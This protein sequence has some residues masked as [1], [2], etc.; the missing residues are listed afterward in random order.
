[1]PE[2]IENGKAK[3]EEMMTDEQRAAEAELETSIENE[4][5]Q[6]TEQKLAQLLDPEFR[7]YGIRFVNIEEYRKIMSERQLMPRE[8]FVFQKGHQ[9]T[10]YDY[11]L[12]FAE[13]SFQEFRQTLIN[14]P[15][16]VPRSLTN[17]DHNTF[18]IRNAREF[19]SELKYAHSEIIKQPSE[20]EGKIREKVMLKFRENIIKSW[21]SRF[22]PKGADKLLHYIDE[23]GFLQERLAYLPES[24]ENDTSWDQSERAYAKEQEAHINTYKNLIGVENWDALYQFYSNSNWLNED[25]NNIRKLFNA[26]SYGLAKTQDEEQRQYHLALAYDISALTSIQYTGARPWAKI[27]KN[28]DEEEAPGMQLLGAVSLMPNQELL[29]EA[30][31]LSSQAKE[32]AHPVFD[33]HGKVSYPHDK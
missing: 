16:A 4:S 23:M 27:R 26:V 18:D 21:Q 9:F 19:L 17:W 2:D 5:L 11:H 6:V 7:S 14:Q 12:D 1:M 25:K 31:A 33:Y 28:F 24:E 8:V 3:P 10:D 30:I 13:P 32:F 20:D 29:R 15:E 22:A